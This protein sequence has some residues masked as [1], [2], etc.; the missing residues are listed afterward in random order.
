MAENLKLAPGHPI[1]F[2]ARAPVTQAQLNAYAQASGDH[3]RI[4]LDETVAKAMGLPG[5]IAH[6]MLSAAFL[7]ERAVRFAADEAGLAH[8]KLAGFQARFKAMTLLGDVISV[9]GSVKEVSVNELV[10]EIQARNQRDE[11]TT[12]GVAKFSLI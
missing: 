5:V 4:H 9:G 2:Q 6:G 11:V 1:S 7:A 3:N 12:S 8:A 10:L